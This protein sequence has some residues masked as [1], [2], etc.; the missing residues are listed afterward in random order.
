MSENFEDK[1]DIK[2]THGVGFN[3]GNIVNSTF[4]K[5]IINDT[6]NVSRKDE[7]AEFPN[8]LNI[9]R[10]G[11]VKF[12]GRDKDI[13]DLHEQLQEKERVSIT[14][15]VTGMAG[16]GKTELA[17]QYSLLSEKEL[18]YPGGI[19]WINVRER[20]VGE[21]LLSFAQTQLGLFPAEDWSLEERISFCWSNWQPPGDVLIVL[22]DVNKYEEIEQYL[23]PQK[24]RFKLL[25]TTRKYW[26][27]ESF[28]Q[29]RLE[30]LDE[31]SALELLEV[32]IGNSRLGTQI[33]EAKQL[34]EWLG[35]LPLGLELVGRFLKRRSEW[36]LERM[37]QELEKQALNFSV[38]QNPPQGEM[39]AQRGVAAAFELNW[40]ELD[41]RG[42]GIWVV[43]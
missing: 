38:L 6:K 27:S 33:E 19:C 12:V 11:A 1:V 31:D 40:N 35:Y 34:C 18:K 15:V 43:Y 26:L 5:T 42:E 10:T 21:Q 29:L 36:T 41:E 23:P 9:L 25:I 22:D 24:Q 17:L 2:E 16:V 30:V 39:T 7:P 32:L 13:K 37:I 3:S 20:S 4:A 14:A 28:S 8:N